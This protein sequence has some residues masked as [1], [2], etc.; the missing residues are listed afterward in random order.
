[1]ELIF[2]RSSLFMR[3]HG[4]TRGD[5]MSDPSSKWSATGMYNLSESQNWVTLSFLSTLVVVLKCLAS[6]SQALTLTPSLAAS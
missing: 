5:K 2:T 6:A 1:V 4:T 3:P